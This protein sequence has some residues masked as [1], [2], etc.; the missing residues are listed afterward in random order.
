[1]RFFILLFLSSL[2]LIGCNSS[3]T[4]G[5]NTVFS[6]ITEE[7]LADG[8]TKKTSISVAVQQP[9]APKDGAVISFK[10]KPDGTVD[11]STST[12]QSQDISNIQAAVAKI[13]ML[14]PLVWAGAALCV[15]GVLA[16]A[17]AGQ[18][19]W[20]A[21]LFIGGLA[22]ALGAAIIAEYAVYFGI[23]G[24]IV[25]IWLLYVLWDNK[26]NK[27]GFIENT[28]VIE[29]IKKELPDDKKEQLF[30]EKSGDV[31][32]IQ[33]SSTKNLVKNTRNKLF[34]KR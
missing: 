6:K 21:G 11:V 33:S 25:V 30:N 16:A 29:R 31:A 13:G 17:I 27:K 28:K 10:D 22:M 4:D 5:G 15:L 12:G 32:L 26:V 24:I 14:H 18:Y 8:G 1:M 3:F 20:G 23:I 19:K 9:E 7:S 2:I 34:S